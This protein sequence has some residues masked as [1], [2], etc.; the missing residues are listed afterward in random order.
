MVWLQNLF[1]AVSQR[2][3]NKRTALEILQS[4]K[5]KIRFR[6]VRPTIGAL[7]TVFG[8]IRLNSHYYSYNTPFDNLHLKTLI[9]HEA[10]QP[11]FGIYLRINVK[12]PNEA[13]EKRMELP[14]KYDRDGLSQALN[15]MQ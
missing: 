11:E 8:Y 10:W 1:V 14:L 9:I 6:K 2:G 5:I 13:I 15:F 4:R 12:Y 3:E 7:W